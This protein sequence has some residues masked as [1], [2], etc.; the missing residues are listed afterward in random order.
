MR[1]FL[2]LSGLS[3]GFGGL[4]GRF[5]GEGGERRG[6]EVEGG[7]EVRGGGGGDIG[8]G[9]GGGEEGLDVRVTEEPVSSCGPLVPCH[10][11]EQE[12]AA[13]PLVLEAAQQVH[14]GVLGPSTSTAAA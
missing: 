1:F 6:S 11:L 10:V 7:G 8:G 2:D 12:G 5:G 14:P 13:R 4:A 9:G 3:F